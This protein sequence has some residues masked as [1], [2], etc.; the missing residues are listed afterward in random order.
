MPMSQSNLWN[1]NW[2]QYTH[3]S[4]GFLI[5]EIHQGNIVQQGLEGKGCWENAEFMWF[6][7]NFMY[8]GV[9]FY[10]IKVFPYTLGN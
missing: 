5:S 2:G 1:K 3:W 9:L 7:S 8:G 4:V 10:A 6:T